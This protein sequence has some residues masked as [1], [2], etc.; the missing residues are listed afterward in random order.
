[1]SGRSLD[2]VLDEELAPTRPLDAM[3]RPL[4]KFDVDREH[5]AVTC[6]VG[7]ASA[8]AV[9]T[10]NLGC[11]LVRPDASRES[12]RARSAPDA[13]DSRPDPKAIDWPLGDRMP[14]TA[15]AGIDV[16]A[17]LRALAAAFAEPAKMHTRAIV[18][19][20]RGQLVAE[21][22]ADGYRADM[23]LP[24]WSMTKTL[25][26]ALLGA[27]V[28]QGKLD[29]KQALAIPEWRGDERRTIGFD[30]LLTMTGGL[31][32]NED[33]ADPNSDALRMLFRSS[34]HAGVYAAC[35]RVA[36]PGTHFCYASGATNLLCRVLRSTFADDREYWSFPRQALFA[37]LGMRTAVLETDPSGTFVGS[38]Y[39]FASAR[40]WARLGLLFAN[41]GRA[42][43]ERI[44]PAGWVAA[45]VAPQPASA[46][47]YGRL[48]WLD[49]DCDG[50][51]KHTREWPDLPADL[52]YMS[53]HEGQYCFVMPAD[54][55]V[56]V[57]LGCAKNGGFAL[58]ALLRDVRAALRP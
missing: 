42:G 43:G 47:R 21:Q 14:E 56:I 18:V 29:P 20:H 5:G 15:A 23:P 33:Y 11:T 51:G 48:T 16:P 28:Q 55:L 46:G 17:V 6:H 8:V 35:A 38:S 19:L 32:W 22:Y 9:A 41:D 12:L 44:L 50:E 25:T 26:Y 49:R 34:D 54:E 27:R 36:A 2:S 10:R 1:V 13:A 30:D 45:G 53:G 31:Q 37:R 24:G 7:A 57:R 58:H 39:G 40:D 4:L 3:I 52:F